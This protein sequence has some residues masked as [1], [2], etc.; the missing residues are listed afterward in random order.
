MT[1]TA[2]RQDQAAGGDE[3]CAF[4]S[5]LHV[6]IEEVGGAEEVGNETID[7][8][9]VKVHGRSHLLQNPLVEHGDPIRDGV[10]FLLVVSHEDGGQLQL[11]LQLENLT[12]HLNAQVGVQIGQR[13]VQQQDPGLDDDGAGKGHSLLLAAGKL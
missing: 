6:S 12:P 8:A 9:V 1:L 10:G 5:N 4:A 13:L 3:A 2:Q 11:P 7:G